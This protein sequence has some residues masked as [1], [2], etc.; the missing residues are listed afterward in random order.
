MQ[1][2]SIG[3]AVD[4]L[5]NISFD[6]AVRNA[7]PGITIVI[8]NW[9]HEYLLP[10]SAGTALQTVRELAKHDIPAEVLVVDD[11]SRD[12]SLTFLRQCEALHYEEGFKVLALSHN[13][14]PSV[15]R[16][17]ALTHASYRY[18][19]MLD[20]D[21][22]LYP[23]N[24]HLYYRTIRETEAALVY[25][26]L[27]FIRG[28]EAEEVHGFQSS[29]YLMF[30]WNYIDTFALVDR[31]QIADVHGYLNSMRTYAREDWELVLR[32]MVLGRRI[33]YLPVM[34]GL[35]HMLPDSR[36]LDAETAE[37]FRETYIKR[38]Y[39]QLGIRLEQPINTIHLRYHPEIGYF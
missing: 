35:Y 10:R 7:P 6:E 25:G 1:Q 11:Q 36:V 28:G 23:K 2:V 5:A 3:R 33:V 29:D 24:V 37:S 32:L 18:L 15:A 27:C 34:L 39:N 9:N 19:L 30:L 26:P 8:P 21:N 14:G 12:G 22:E 16:N 17:L 31:Q 4:R 20:A 13:Q 38:I